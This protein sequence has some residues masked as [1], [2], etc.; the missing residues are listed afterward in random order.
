MRK[1]IVFPT[2]LLVL[3]MKPF[4]PKTHLL[5][6]KITLDDWSKNSTDLNFIISVYFLGNIFLSI[7]IFILFITK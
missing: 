4:L 2:W 6:R 5:K 3:I 1:I 7:F